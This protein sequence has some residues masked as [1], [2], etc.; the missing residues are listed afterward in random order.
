D[1]QLLSNFLGCF[2]LNEQL[3]HFPLPGRQQ[4]LPFLVGQRC[5][6]PCPSSENTRVRESVNISYVPLI[7]GVKE[8]GQFRRFRHRMFGSPQA[9]SIIFTISP[10]GDWKRPFHPRLPPL[11]RPA[12]SLYVD[13]I[14]DKLRCRRPPGRPHPLVSPR[15]RT[16]LSHSA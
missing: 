16:S 15:G 5:H 13:R 3:K 8:R 1:E 4:R 14:R 11:H 10:P 7:A 12:S 2:V 6:P 9:F